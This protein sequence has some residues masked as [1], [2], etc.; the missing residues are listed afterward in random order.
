LDVYTKSIAN[1]FK[2]AFPG[3]TSTFCEPTALFSAG[4]APTAAAKVL[5]I[6]HFATNRFF[7]QTGERDRLL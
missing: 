5:V 3:V 2:A 1:P 7:Q 6:G 4:N